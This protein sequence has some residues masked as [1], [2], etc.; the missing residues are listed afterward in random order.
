MWTS[1]LVILALVAALAGLFF[2][3][4]S[5]YDAVVHLDRQVHGIHCSYLGL[6]ST[7]ASGTSGC[8]ATLMSPY[9]SILRH[10]IWGGTPIAL[11]AMS[12][13]SFIAFWSLWLLFTGRHLETR[14]VGFLWAA[15]A[16]PV[17][18]SAVM[19]YLA[20]VTLDA[21][22]KLCI[23]IYI[24]SVV[25]CAATTAGYFLARRHSSGPPSG[26]PKQLSWRLLAA[27][28]GGGVLFV[29]LPVAVYGVVAPDFSHYI[30][31]C[32]ALSVPRSSRTVLVDLPSGGRGDV[33]VIEL[34]DPLCGAC[35]VFARRFS[36]MPESRQVSLRVLLFPLDKACN[37]MVDE[38]IHPGSCTVSEAVLCAGDQAEE[39][40]GWAFEEQTQLL[41]AARQDPTS[42]QRRVL[43]RFPALGACLGG[44]EVQARLNKS[45]RWVVK[46]R[47]QVLTPQIFVAGMRLCNEDTDLGLEYALSRL[48]SQ[49]RARLHQ[50][51]SDETSAPDIPVPEKPT[52]RPTRALPAPRPAAVGA[53]AVA[54]GDMSAS[55]GS[56]ATGLPRGDARSQP[57]PQ[58]EPPPAPT[59]RD[60]PPQEPP[61]A[62]GA[63]P[64]RAREGK[65]AI[66]RAAPSPKEAP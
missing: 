61:P 33:E 28:F 27:A 8:H 45:L 57:A 44:A 48:I 58:V 16:L 29:A 64:D 46:N 13:F 17:L 42:V 52:G 36:A 11:P 18:S 15:T 34:L 9:S 20:L 7:D 24:S 51:V 5:T 19:G 63:E 53:A 2:S 60:E 1:R 31:N 62:P 55:R 37:W 66:P 38:T 30:G 21:V 26:V 22:C 50:R 32:G 3:T 40:L 56:T 4:V 25:A 49:A 59:P 39:V 35:N 12:V 10:S 47:L 54:K 6:G 43:Q 65:P 14:A 41:Q 23:G